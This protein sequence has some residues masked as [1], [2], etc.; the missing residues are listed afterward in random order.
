MATIP[1]LIDLIRRHLGGIDPKHNLADL[2]A[3][4]ATGKRVEL[5]EGAAI[6]SGAALTPGTDGNVFHVTGT[7]TIT[8][9]AAITGAGPIW[10]IFDGALTLTHNAT[11]LILMGGASVTTVAGDVFCFMHEGSG[12]YRELA[13]SK[14]ASVVDAG[15]MSKTDKQN[16]TH[17]DD[18][19]VS[20]AV[21][22][23]YSTG[24]YK[25]ITTGGNITGI[26]LSNLPTG[27]PVYLAIKYGG[28]HTVAWTTTINWTGGTAPV[29]TETNDKRDIFAFIKHADTKISGTADLN[30]GVA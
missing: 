10:L 8:S 26:T 17:D 4:V 18:G 11:S 2:S 7:T 30:H 28:A 3:M 13:R 14:M 12:N 1:E 29:E 15:L 5:V 19:T 24:G 16:V 21:T 20:G 23:D 9:I 6:A 22:V 27:V 25:E